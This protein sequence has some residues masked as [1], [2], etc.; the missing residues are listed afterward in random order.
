MAGLDFDN[1]TFGYDTL[2]EPLIAGVTV[3]FPEGWTGIVGANG[4]GK[5]TVLLLAAG[6]LKPLAGAIHRPRTIVYCPQRTDDPP[7]R[8]AE[9]LTTPNAI[10]CELRGRLGVQDDYLARWATLSHGERKRAQ[11]AA[12]LWQQPD[13]L[14]LDEPSNHI[15]AAARNLLIRELKAYDGVGLLVSHDRA[16]LDGLCRQCLFI[17]HGT[18]NMRRGG[19]T[20]G[21]AAGDEQAENLRVRHD[22]AK[23][24]LRRI[25]REMVDRR[26]RAAGE[27]K[28]RSKRGLSP[29][30]HDAKEK[31]DRARVADSK[32]GASLRQLAGRAEQAADKLASIRPHW[33]ATAG[34][35]V[36]DSRSRRDHLFRIDA[37]Q[38]PL[39]ERRVLEFPELAMPPDGRVAIVGP[40]GSGKST[41]VRH[42]IANLPL[43]EGRVLYMPQEI[44]AGQS[45]RILDEVRALDH[46]RLGQVMN[47]V[48]RLGSRV[49]PLLQTQL[50]SPGEIRKILLALG[51]VRACHLIILDEPTN[52]LDLPSIECLEQALSD[53]PCGLLLV[54]HDLRFLG[55]LVREF[56]AL[57]P[58]GETVRLRISAE[59]NGMNE[60]R[61]SR[62]GE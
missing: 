57:E 7:P 22:R 46:I 41:L 10:A 14:A 44:E 43:P 39:G 38:V 15:D 16:M 5:T 21:R 31:I 33:E 36:G 23:G 28:M 54:S 48:S 27:G 6:V 40:N 8:F 56:W 24:Q 2:G 3:Q 34:I 32:S 35:W 1:V 19:Y 50:P 53:C 59:M 12:A 37:G 42:L 17:E 52:H 18:A 11:I 55:K 25:E 58:A 29:K 13:A 9:F 26:Q 49:E 47:I 30:D 60:I 61:E 20:Q 45:L 62:P 51:I 4:A